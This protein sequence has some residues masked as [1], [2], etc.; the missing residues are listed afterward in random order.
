MNSVLFL[1]LEMQEVRAL[2]TKEMH[3]TYIFNKFDTFF[4]KTMQSIPNILNG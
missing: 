3:N 2:P 1:V 4:G